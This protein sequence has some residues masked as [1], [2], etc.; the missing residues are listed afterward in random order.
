[1]KRTI[2]LRAVFIALLSMAVIMTV[3][4]AAASGSG[5]PARCGS[6]CAR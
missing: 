2:I 3:M 1:M 5:L 6:S 4:P